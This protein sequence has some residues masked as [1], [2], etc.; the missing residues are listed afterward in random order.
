[1]LNELSLHNF[2][3]IAPHA[4]INLSQLTILCGSNSS[5]KS[6]LIQAILM[7]SQAFSSRY[8]FDTMVLNGHLVRLGAFKDIVNQ[9]SS[10]KEIT[11][12]FK[13]RPQGGLP[14][15]P[16]PSLIEYSCTFGSPSTGSPDDEYHP[17]ILKTSLR[18]HY[19]REGE[20]RVETLSTSRNWGQGSDSSAPG[21][22]FKV[23]DISS[24]EVDALAKEYP[25]LKITACESTSFIPTTLIGVY[26]QSKK[27][28][29]QTI[30]LMTG[31]TPSRL[32]KDVEQALPVPRAF[33]SKLRDC[34]AHERKEVEK[35]L[36]TSDELRRVIGDVVPEVAERIL[37]QVVEINL[38][39][40]EKSI[41]IAFS[42]SERTP[43]RDW[44]AFLAGTEE[45]HRK[46]FVSIIDKYRGDLMSAW[47]DSQQ[48]IEEGRFTFRN[49]NIASQYLTQYF[50]KSVKYL[51]PLRNEPKAVYASEGHSDP[52]NVGLKGE[53]TAAALHMNRDR[54]I[55]YP[56]PVVDSK[57]V[58]AISMK[59]STLARAC[60][61]WLSYLG[62][63]VDYDTSD[64]GKL[65][66]EISVKV[67]SKDNWQ[68]LTHVGVGV[69][70]VLPIVLMALLS[71][72]GELLIFEQPELHLHPKVQSRL[73]D[74]FCALAE[75]GRQSIIETHSEYFINRLRL[76]IVQESPPHLGEQSS[77][78]FV[79]K[80][81]GT[82]SFNPVEINEFGAILQWPE[83]FFDQT[84]L[85]VE[86]IL[87]EAGRKRR[88]IKEEA[89]ARR[90]PNL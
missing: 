13:M 44:S 56:S 88:R 64:K 21:A 68:D 1:M 46:A 32:S 79:T 61:E 35:T 40:S 66:Y 41:P 5:G 4:D 75:A 12:S 29:A 43:V 16:V 70:Q 83:D 84:D 77:V 8:D 57:G 81:Q 89:S 26:N 82:S 22:R 18:L 60:K 49:L 65:G 74:F 31:K 20:E 86:R 69:S 53:Y 51:G 11:I 15:V 42:S 19:A 39:V 6:S 17:K 36:R 85:E 33:F 25:D 76:R 34:I 48:D 78:F 10:G 28:A 72:P 80:G 90:S 30:G 38:P 50:A 87:M 54:W 3:A 47:D 71:E 24:P 58:L 45:S 67:E 55:Y 37:A 62:V 7:L 2:K 59:R 63:I 73:C 9:G 27:A 14:H 52:K 23:D